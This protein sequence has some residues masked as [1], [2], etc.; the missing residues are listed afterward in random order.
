VKGQ[1]L[2][3]I[4]DAELVG[5]V[6]NDEEKQLK[7]EIKESFYKGE[8]M[9]VDKSVE[10]LSEA[11]VANLMGPRIVQAAVN[12]G[13][14]NPAAILTIAGVPHVQIVIM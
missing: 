2:V 4:C 3:A 9:E 10:L 12:A 13:H 14:V 11:T 7:V 5:K 6:L 8:I 1:V